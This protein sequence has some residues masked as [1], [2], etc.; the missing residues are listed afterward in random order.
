[1]TIDTEQ[2]KKQL[3]TFQKD[4][5][6]LQIEFE[7]NSLLFKI[8]NHASELE[9]LIDDSAKKEASEL[10]DSQLTDIFYSVG[11][12]LSYTTA[13][14]SLL[15]CVPLFTEGNYDGILY[16]IVSLSNT[17]SDLASREYQES[18]N[19]MEY[20][21]H[22]IFN[23]CLRTLDQYG[24]ELNHVLQVMRKSIFVTL[25]IERRA[26]MNNKEGE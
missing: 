11:K 3:Q 8:I 6:D 21:C 2:A 20:S 12:L 26:S 19:M 16:V 24:L 25:D 1:M 10:T 7:L 15:G 13:L 9:I 18:V 4:L 5:N 17:G 23:I 14:M 22:R